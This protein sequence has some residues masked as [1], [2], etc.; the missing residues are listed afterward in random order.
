VLEKGV[1]ENV[2]LPRPALESLGGPSW[3]R[4]TRQHFEVSRSTGAEEST[5]HFPPISRIQRYPWGILSRQDGCLTRSVVLGNPFIL[6]GRGL[7][8]ACLSF[9]D[10]SGST[11]WQ[12][13]VLGIGQNLRSLGTTCWAITCDTDKSASHRPPSSVMCEMLSE[14]MNLSAQ[15]AH[16]ILAASRTQPP[17][18]PSETNASP[19]CAEGAHH[20]WNFHAST[21]G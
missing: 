7:S 4:L 14:A 17:A 3:A 21:P 18:C 10:P 16:A 20:G 2:R 1:T 13:I 12:C 11:F 19:Q 15:D 9:G 8:V 5:S 6:Y